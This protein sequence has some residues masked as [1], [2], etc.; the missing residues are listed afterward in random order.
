MAYNFVIGKFSSA[1]LGCL[2]GEKESLDTF[3]EMN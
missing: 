3:G 1:I 2:G